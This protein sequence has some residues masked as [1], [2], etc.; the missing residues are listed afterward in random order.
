[1]WRSDENNFVTI[2]SA[3]KG[4][5]HESEF[6]KNNFGTATSKG[7]NAESCIVIAFQEASNLE[8]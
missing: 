6:F 5:F 3:V 2:F 4:K 1:M 8:A 7:G